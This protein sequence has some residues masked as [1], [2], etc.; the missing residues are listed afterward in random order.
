MVK[1]VPM[2]RCISCKKSRPK[3]EL[4]R[5]VM[6]DGVAVSDDMKKQ[7]GRGFYICKDSEKCVTIAVKKGK[8]KDGNK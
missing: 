4:M 8:L 6:V 2:R 1:E 7:N 5:Y 3:E